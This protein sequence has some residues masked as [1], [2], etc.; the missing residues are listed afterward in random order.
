MLVDQRACGRS[1]RPSPQTWTLERYAQ[2]VIMLARSL[3]LDR[4]GVLGHSYGA[5]VALQHGV[6][7]RA[8]LRRW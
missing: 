4:Y 1:E 7:Y 5:F 6:D 8:W 2:D 3:G